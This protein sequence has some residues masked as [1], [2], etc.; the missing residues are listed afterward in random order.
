MSRESAR[1]P[2]P[3]KATPKPPPNFPQHNLPEPFARLL[4]IG[5]DTEFDAYDAIADEIRAGD[6]QAGVKQ[7]AAMAVDRTYDD[8]ASFYP[9]DADVYEIEPRLSTRLNVLGV[10]GELGEAAG[11]AAEPLLAL[12]NDNDDDVFIG[13]VAIEPL[14]RALNDPGREDMARANAADGLAEIGQRHPELQS[15]LVSIIEQAML[16]WP[17]DPQLQGF[18]VGAL[19]DMGA[20]DSLPIIE[21][22]FRAGRVDDSVLTLEDVQE[23]FGLTPARFPRSPVVPAFAPEPTGAQEE[24]EP[25]AEPFVAG[26]KV[27]RNDPC[28]CGSGKKYKKCCGA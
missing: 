10:L 9:E 24:E 23:H 21:E 15:R 12:L 5:D 3:P 1:R 26:P 27:G 14:T 25:A 18:L 2:Q 20:R 11:D 7:L 8:Y 19:L 16:S 13:E 6:V 4:T 28:P 22:A 17:G